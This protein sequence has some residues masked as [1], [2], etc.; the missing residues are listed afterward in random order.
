[1]DTKPTKRNGAAV[2]LTAAAVTGLSVLAAVPAQ[3]AP[4]RCGA[5]DVT[6]STTELPAPVAQERLYELTIRATPGTTCLAGGAPQNMIFYGPSGALPMPVDTPEPGTGEQVVVAA[7][8]PAAVYLSGPKTNGPARATSVSFTLP[9]DTTPIHIGWV[10]GGVDGPLRAGTI[11]N[12][13]S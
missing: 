10:R 4:P 11:T 13:V 6:V 5:D 9:G 1:M 7:G 3:A 2:A 8:Q 12:P